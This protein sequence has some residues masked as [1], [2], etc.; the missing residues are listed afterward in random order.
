MRLADKL[1]DVALAAEVILARLCFVEVPEHIR[2]HGVD[3]DGM[4]DAQAV[5]PVGAGCADVVHIAGDDL[6]GFAVQLKVS[7]NGHKAVLRRRGLRQSGR[8]NHGQ[9]ERCTRAAKDGVHNETLGERKPE[10]RN[11]QRHG[12]FGKQR[13][14]Q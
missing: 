9:Q 6:E 2:H 10:Y 5:A 1:G 11:P 3:S 8:D 14:L 12:Y 13:E 7:V 4:G